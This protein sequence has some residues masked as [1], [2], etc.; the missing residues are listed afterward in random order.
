MTS[1]VIF[2]PHPTGFPDDAQSFLLEG[3][4]VACGLRQT[5]APSF[6]PDD[7]ADAERVLVRKRAFSCNYR[8]RALMLRL[9]IDA[10]TESW[11]PIGSDF[12]AEVVAVGRA[13]GGLRPGDRVIGNAAYPYSGVEGV[14]AGVPSN[15]ASRALA[16]FHQAKLFP[17][18]AAMPDDLAAGFT[19]GGQTTY[20]MIRKLALAPGERVLITGG[21]S[22]TGLFALAALAGRGVETHV[23]TTSPRHVES[24]RRLGAGEVIVVD[25]EAPD[26]AGHPA[27][28]AVMAAGGYNAVIDP[29]ADVYL[30]HAPALMAMGGRYVTCGVFDQHSAL[31]GEKVTTNRPPASLLL[32]VLVKNL[33]LMGNCIG[34][35]TDL[36]E[37]VAD[38]AAGRLAP[39]VD[40]VWSGEDC[41]AFLDR[42]Y[43]AAERFGKVVFRY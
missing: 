20:S 10:P 34:A 23:S 12:V 43:N 9:A 14:R 21:R 36:A 6:D 24:L 35:T 31:T 28:A 30:A 40:S 39:P 18:P 7:P 38:Q 16:V 17:I 22:N 2:G 37:A 5:Q 4:R 42:G 13:V 25:R 41:A 8:D 1:L 11:S 3:V 19:I 27:V 29:F 33:T 26:F 32:H 15:Q